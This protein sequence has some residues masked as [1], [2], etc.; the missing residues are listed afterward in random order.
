MDRMEYAKALTEEDLRIIENAYNIRI[1][2]MRQLFTGADKNTFVYEVNTGKENSGQKVFFLK[3]R[4]GD[5]IESSIQIPHFLFLNNSAHIIDPV[6]TVRGQLYLKMADHAVVLYPFIRG[7]SGREA[8][9][10]KT[11]WIE[12]G[13]ALRKIHDTI[14]PLNTAKIPQETYDGRWRNK[15]KDYMKELKVKTIESEYARSFVALYDGKRELINKMIFRTEELLKEIQGSKQDHCLCHGDIHAA[16]LLVINKK[17]FKIVD[18]DTLIMAPGE[19]DLMFIGGGVTHK[20]NT[21]EEEHYFYEGYGGR[22]KVNRRLIVYYRFGRIIE[23]L[24]EYYEQFFTA[25]I[26]EKN[27][28]VIL[29]IVKNQ[30][31]PNDVVD[32]AFRGDGS[33]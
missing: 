3:I 2:G 16:N 6:K 31:E 9:L 32:M 15:L 23:D 27:Q 18:W 12:F 13:A 14:L 29:E 26:G 4:T 11:Q 8:A 22:E 21:A 33:A 10:T 25:G 7:K 5:F 24:A 20:W 28:K 30:F 19:R 1:T 17:E